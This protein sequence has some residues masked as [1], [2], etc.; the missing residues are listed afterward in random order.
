[1]K[2]TI[3]AIEGKKIVCVFL[4]NFALIFFLFERKILSKNV[5]LVFSRLV[6]CIG[7]LWARLVR[8]IT[9]LL[10]VPFLWATDGSSTNERPRERNSA[11]SSHGLG[12]KQGWRTMALSWPAEALEAAGCLFAHLP[13]WLPG[14]GENCQASLQKPASGARLPIHHL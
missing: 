2:V 8:C 10:A 11:K 13:A 1:M 12:S 4:K 6:R 5:F 3:P 9:L 14:L 7:F